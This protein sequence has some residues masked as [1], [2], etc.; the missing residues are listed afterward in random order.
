[1]ARG[2]IKKKFTNPLIAFTNIGILDK[3]RLKFG[4]VEITK[5]YMTGSIKYSPY[6]QLA[7]STF[8]NQA[9]LSVN[10]YGTQSDRNTISFFLDKLVQE[11]N[12]D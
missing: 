7:I 4:K 6:F 9:I 2:I 12:V 8:D 1:M 11:L 3:T 5:A 10:L